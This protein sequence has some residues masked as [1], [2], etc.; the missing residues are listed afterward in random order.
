[1]SIRVIR[2]TESAFGALLALKVI[3]EKKDTTER[4]GKEM[5]G[6]WASD[7]ASNLTY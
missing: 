2:N 4:K 6:D 3:Y 1:M 7:P 5:G